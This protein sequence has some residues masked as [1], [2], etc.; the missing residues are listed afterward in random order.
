MYRVE[1]VK[2]RP[3]DHLL[4]IGKSKFSRGEHP[5][6][7]I[8]R[9]WSRA[10]ES[11]LLQEVGGYTC[12]PLREFDLS[13]I[14]RFR[15]VYLTTS[16][17]E[18]L[19]REAVSSLGSF[20][21][22][23][24]TLVVEGSAARAFDPCGVRLRDERQIF[25]RVT[26]IKR[27]AWP[28][29]L[30]ECL[31]RMPLYTSGYP[32]DSTETDVK[33]ILEMEGV[34]AVLERRLGQGKIVILTFDFGA[35]L[36]GLQQ[37][38]PAQGRKQL[39]KLFGTQTRVVEPEDLV[40]T[41]SLLDNPIPWAD[42]LERFLFR[43]ITAD[44]PAP[45]WW[46]FPGKY[47]GA[48]ISTHDDE[49]IGWDPRLQKM[50]EEER[51]LGVRGTL[52]VISDKR[53]HSRWGGN[54]ALRRT[55]RD[56]SEIALH[57]NRFE[58]PRLKIRS[59]KFGMHEF[60]LKDQLAL[61]E[62]E[63]GGPV[64]INRSHFLALGRSY[65]EHFERLAGHGILLDSTYGPNQGGRGYLFGSGY[66]YHGLTWEGKL[67]GVFELPFQTQEM[68]GGA[69]LAFLKRL[70]SESGEIYHQAVVMNFHPHY[71][72]TREKGRE[73]WLESLRFAREK[74]QWIPTLGEFFKFFCERNESVIES[75]WSDRR[76]T[77]NTEAKGETL[78]LSLPV[79]PSAGGNL[80]QVT[81]D[82]SLVTP[83]RVGNA[84]FEECLVPVPRGKHTVEADYET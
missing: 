54:G 28:R 5:A 7:F 18:E 21:E 40:L 65:G 13:Q 2:M 33:G 39:Q 58:K 49:A 59:F 63:T 27:D 26:S 70:I 45:R 47:P 64:R 81:V 12:C 83:E 1:R 38:L 43:V 41:A 50:E 4:L 57:W 68:W 30:I 79:R 53:L 17:G 44:A 42:L 67:S 78:T 60:P 14:A 9:D 19:S 48:L 15:V 75:H 10:W 73:M 51:K 52:F 71:T 82:G 31:L 36:T 76:L 35:L 74:S 6:S 61:L 37:G 25:K 3:S 34:P 69:D 22:S 29:E 11:F 77:I 24:G 62:K 16:A 55:A 8:D 56:G 46:Y 84:W 23:G 80:P 32:V 66:P 72:I 20:V